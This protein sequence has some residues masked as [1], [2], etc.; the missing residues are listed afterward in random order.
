[1]TELWSAG[2][3]TVILHHLKTTAV[4]I[5][6]NILY[7]IYGLGKNVVNLYNLLKE[8]LKLL[9]NVYSQ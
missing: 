7:K 9:N 8:I 1:M 3:I 2:K 6:S 5:L 4:N